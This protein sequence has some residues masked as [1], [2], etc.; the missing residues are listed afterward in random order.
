M[1]PSVFMSIMR[2]PWAQTRGITAS[3]LSMSSSSSLMDRMLSKMHEVPNNTEYLGEV[4]HVAKM[5]IFLLLLTQ[6]QG[7]VFREP[8][9]LTGNVSA[10]SSSSSSSSSSAN[11]QP[12]EALSTFNVQ[13]GSKIA[14]V[15]VSESLF[16]VAAGRGLYKFVIG[17]SLLFHHSNL[18]YQYFG[19][20]H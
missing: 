10:T 3:S 20:I 9:L 7:C 14:A 5:G 6:S 18:S 1:S 13:M 17:F 4:Q 12:P 11:T 16:S 8:D 19:A 15:R 2:R